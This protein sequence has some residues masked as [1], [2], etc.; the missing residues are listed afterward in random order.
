MCKKNLATIEVVHAITNH[1]NAKN[2]VTAHVKGN[3]VVMRRNDVKLGDKVVLIRKDAIIPEGTEWGDFLYD[4]YNSGRVKS[5]KFRHLESDCIALPFKAF[6]GTTVSF[7]DHRVGS[8]IS[9]ELG[10]TEYD[11]PKKRRVVRG[12]AGKGRT[13]KQVNSWLEEW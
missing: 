9:S 13:N 3:K 6:K 7:K 1:I 5:H 12:L 8:D 11:N 10:I 2:I 4:W